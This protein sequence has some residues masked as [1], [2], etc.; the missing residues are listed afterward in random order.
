MG[1]S[2]DDRGLKGSQKAM[3]EGRE[4]DG[5]STGRW[6]NAVDRDAKGMLK[7]GTWIRSA[8]DK[9]VILKVS[10]FLKDF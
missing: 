1:G 6:L 4:P 10:H 9:D 7:C 3:T 2:C 8:E 5:G